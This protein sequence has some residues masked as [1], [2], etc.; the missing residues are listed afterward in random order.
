MRGH[1]CTVWDHQMIGHWCM[2]VAMEKGNMAQ[3][4]GEVRKSVSEEM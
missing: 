4:S 2:F 1:V 3:R